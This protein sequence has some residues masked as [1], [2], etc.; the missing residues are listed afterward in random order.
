MWIIQMTESISRHV[1]IEQNHQPLTCFTHW[2]YWG[3][4]ILHDRNA[5]T[6]KHLLLNLTEYISFP[7]PKYGWCGITTIKHMQH[8]SLTADIATLFDFPSFHAFLVFSSMVFCRLS[9]YLGWAAELLFNVF[10]FYTIQLTYYLCLIVYYSCIV[11]SP[12]ILLIPSH[13]ILV[14]CK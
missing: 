1:T 14:M 10:Y 6:G 11:V 13:Y 12:L 8:H 7:M 4:R 3:T 5:V 2:S 9:C